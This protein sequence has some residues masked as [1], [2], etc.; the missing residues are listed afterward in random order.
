MAARSSKT[1]SPHW[2]LVAA[3]FASGVFIGGLALFLWLGVQ[4]PAVFKI[5][6][7]QKYPYINPILAVDVF[8]NRQFGQNHALELQVEGLINDHK[9][10]GGITS[11]TVYYRDIEPG[12]WFGVG[13]DQK[14]SPGRLL[15][16]PI[17]ISYF[18]LAESNPEILNQRITFYGEAEVQPLLG[19]RQLPALVRGHSYSVDELIQK[20]IVDTDNAAANTLFD[21][22]DKQALGEVFSD[23]GI[24]FHEDKET[25]DF[26]AL[27]LY[28][29]FFRI[30][31]NSSYLN[32]EYSE[33]ALE[34]LI[35]GDNTIGLGANLPKSVP[36]ANRWGVRTIRNDG[37]SQVELYDCG[38]IFFPHHPYLM[39]ATAIGG[40]LAPVQDFL[41][42][43]GELVYNETKYR[44]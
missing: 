14:F 8:E 18:K 9:R 31:Y 28:S 7:T 44:Y 4:S 32:R 11:A 20:M 10:K 27:K 30:L 39:C 5:H 16:I 25:Q 21:T 41:K 40:G 38:I 22:I 17:M 33:R 37:K 1:L 36:F 24:D 13:A 34:I 15:K 35:Q 23:L 19:T 12:I 26:I 29:L 43:L 2:L 3:F 6:P 42:E